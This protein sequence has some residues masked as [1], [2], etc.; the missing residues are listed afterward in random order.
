MT[1]INKCNDESKKRM[2]FGTCLIAIVLLVVLVF[3]LTAPSVLYDAS[4]PKDESTLYI[5][6]L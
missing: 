1:D 2:S 4:V 6:I 5:Y 3:I